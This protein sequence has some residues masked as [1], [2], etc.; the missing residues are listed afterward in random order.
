MVWEGGWIGNSHVDLREFFLIDQVRSS[1][2]V[3]RYCEDD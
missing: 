1:Y 3:F 2:F